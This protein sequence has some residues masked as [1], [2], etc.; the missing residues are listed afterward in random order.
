MKVLQAMAGA[1]HGGA[2]AFFP[3]LAIALEKAG[4]DQRIV[5]RSDSKRVTE[6][7]DGGIEPVQMRFGGGL[8]FTTK[9]DLKRE[10][11]QYKPD[12]VLT[13]MNRATDKC[14]SGDFIHVARLGGYY[15]L[16]YYQQCDHLI[17]NTPD[18]VQYLT[19]EGWP[20]DKA[21]YLSNFVSDD[22]APPLSRS[23]LYIPN[24]ATVLLAMG[25]LHENKAFD[26]LFEAI[27]R[28]PEAYLLLAGEGPL[29]DELKAKAE[30]LGVKPRVRFLGWRDDTA[31]LLATCD[32]FI[33][34][35]RH[36]PLGNVVVEAW[37]HS[38]PVIAAASQGP[39]MLIQDSENGVLFPIDDSK[40]LNAAIKRVIADDDLRGKIA[41]NGRVSYEKD[42]TE[43]RVVEK[44][45][46]FF[47]GLVE[48]ER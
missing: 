46:N 7:R 15:D 31:A 26:V 9:F 48:A 24:G 6:L 35:S 30:R 36:E 2:E 17:G 18:I 25:R 28:M 38:A 23:D 32:V 47:K 4:L 33:C 42:F 16:K 21:H 14:P 37:A 22:A 19:G 1:E 5:I 41:S 13:W 43:A 45:M 39:S 20:R 40:A 29:R 27:E 34:P 8:D 10:I 44:Y 12:I 11:G 3:R